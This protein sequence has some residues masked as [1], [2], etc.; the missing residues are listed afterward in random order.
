MWDT[1]FQSLRNRGRQFERSARR[2]AWPRNSELGTR[3]LRSIG[4]TMLLRKNEGGRII[5]LWGKGERSLYRKQDHRRTGQLKISSMIVLPYPISTPRR[6]PVLQR[7]TPTPKSWQGCQVTHG[8]KTTIHKPWRRVPEATSN[9]DLMPKRW[10]NLLRRI[11]RR[12]SRKWQSKAY[13]N[14]CR[15]S[16][17]SGDGKSLRNATT[18]SEWSMHRR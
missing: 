13:R 1:W 17:S 14:S 7:A 18:K 6:C 3:A 15:T 8:S 4:I 10:T 16:S 12:I 11:L 9:L 5:I 2:P